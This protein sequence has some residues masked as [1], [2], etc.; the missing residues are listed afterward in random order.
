[1]DWEDDDKQFSSYTLP[2]NNV[3]PKATKV[4]GLTKQ[5]N[6]LHFKGKRVKTTSSRR[7]CF[8]K[9]KKYLRKSKDEVQD[10][11]ILVGHYAFGFDAPVLINNFNQEGLKCD[12]IH[13]YIDTMDFFNEYLPGMAHEKYGLDNLCGR[14][15]IERNPIHE[16]LQDSMD[17]KDLIKTVCDKRG[18][19]FMDYCNKNLKR[20]SQ[21]SL[22]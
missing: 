12:N 4:N 10:S 1:M 8:L 2:R 19:S 18:L 14:F 3:N 7:S 16:G 5:G 21:I 6:Q 9:F 20:P 15:G 22:N 13:G 17:L 11:I